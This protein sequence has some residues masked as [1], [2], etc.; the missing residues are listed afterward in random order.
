[1]AREATVDTTARLEIKTCRSDTW[2][3][4][5]TLL[6]TSTLTVMA[7][8][9]I[10]PSLPAMQ[11]NF[12]TVPNSD[13]WVRLV[14]TMP[15]L[16]IVFGAPFA[17]MIVD[18]FGRKRLLIFAALLYGLAGSAG[19]L[20]PSL[21][22]L[23][24]SRALLG[25]SVA[26]LMTSVTTLI[27]DYYD[28][29][30]R[31]RILGFQAA[32]M[33]LGGTVFLT[34]GGFLAD[35]DWRNPFLIYLF[36]FAILP[37]I[38]MVLFE[39][40]RQR[41]DEPIVPVYSP[42]DCVAEAQ[43]YRDAT[44]DVTAKTKAHT[45]PQVPVKLLLF[46]YS[47]IFVTQIAFYLIPVQLPFYL[48]ALVRASAAQSGFAVSVTPFCFASGALLSARI[49]QRLAH[50]PLV[51]FSL[52]LAS[53]GFI[54]IGMVESYYLMFSGLALVGLGFG[55]MIPHLSAWLASAIP[56][57]FRGSALGGLTTFTFLGQFLSPIVAQ[58]VIQQFNLNGMYLMAG[59]LLCVCGI[60]V[61]A[62]FGLR[63]LRSS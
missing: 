8:A 50:I 19:Y 44:A 25:L 26:G 58:P 60:V 46:I 39:P 16:F 41:D 56:E 52:V 61:A 9:I 37:F 2:L 53:L 14:L 6:V 3:V 27:A 15:A 24:V 63:T 4:K 35:L 20:L 29:P 49:S 17:G 33:G 55:F 48:E 42:E 18:R 23:L 5:M 32:F 45:E 7:G 11:E 28:G 59:G 40:R 34:T 13:F 43:R 54:I 12:A 10:A 57:S 51:S 62:V 36:A 1:M 21:T 30:A 31:A 22:A 47:M 38:V